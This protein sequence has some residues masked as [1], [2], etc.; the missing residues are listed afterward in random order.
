MDVVTQKWISQIRC[1]V[2]GFFFSLFV[3][4]FCQRIK[5]CSGWSQ[6]LSFIGCVEVA[7]IF[8]YTETNYSFSKSTSISMLFVNILHM[9]SFLLIYKMHHYFDL[10]NLHCAVLFEIFSH[11][12]IH[13]M[14]SLLKSLAKKQD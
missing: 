14:T 9:T 8:I 6:S 13:F 2:T 3:Q 7:S 1:A 5:S 12:F 4:R 11:M 10:S